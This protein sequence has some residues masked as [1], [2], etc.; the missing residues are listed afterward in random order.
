ML[1][2]IFPY[3]G[4]NFLAYEQFKKWI[5][6]PHGPGYDS[7]HKLI[8]GSMAGA[9]A[10]TLTYPLDMIRARLAYQLGHDFSVG[11]TTTLGSGSKISS[12][13]G[14]S[15][16][17]KFD[18]LQV[19]KAEAEAAKGVSC[20]L[21]TGR[22]PMM[23]FFFGT[24]SLPTFGRVWGRALS[25]IIFDGRGISRFYRGYS[26]SLYG[27]V[28]Y[29]GVSFCTFE[30]L[31]RIF[32]CDNSTTKKFLAGLVAGACGQTAAYPFDVVRRR[33]Q[34]DRVASH[35]P[36]YRS[37]KEALHDIYR[38]SGIRGL[39]I[40]ISIN[41][42]KVAPATAISFVTYEALAKR[43]GALGRFN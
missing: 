31:K 1:L 19:V 32:S 18:A 42:M 9:T 4:T 2:R 8:C 41:Y 40:G 34:L 6:F 36:V 17:L 3:A 27:I 5:H 16:A 23:R 29:A 15:P 33:M 24:S 35:I 43:L 7:L 21:R 38:T 26:A 39:Y 25:T 13:S 20:G 28:P 10:V 22:S 11:G 37:I 14:I 30:T 12:V